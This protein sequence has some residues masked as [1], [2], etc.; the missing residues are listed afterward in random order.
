MAQWVKNPTAVSWVTPEMSIQSPAQWG[1]KDPTQV[2][3]LAWVQSLAWE[4]P[5]AVDMAI[6]F[7]N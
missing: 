3:A 4:L 5:Y 7:F 6:I 2:T 1:L